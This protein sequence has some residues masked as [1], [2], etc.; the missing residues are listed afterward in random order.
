MKKPAEAGFSASQQ[1]W[2]GR[3]NRGLTCSRLQ[4]LQARKRSSELL[5]ALG[6]TRQAD[7]F[8]KFRWCVCV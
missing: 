6:M 4:V 8:A 1:S 7:P 5:G 2:L 3:D